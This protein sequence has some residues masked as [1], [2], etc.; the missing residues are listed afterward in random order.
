M[1]TRRKRED[2]VFRAMVGARRPLRHLRS[3]EDLHSTPL[4]TGSGSGAGSCHPAPP[5]PPPRA[6]A[7]ARPLPA[8]AGTGSAGG[9][10]G[11]RLRL[12]TF[13]A[14]RRRSC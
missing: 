8:H 7:A 14:R 3:G 5:P 9:R 12:E 6:A 4:G 1:S 10:E 11:P 2:S 13:A